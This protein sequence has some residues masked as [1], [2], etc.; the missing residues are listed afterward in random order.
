MDREAEIAWLH[1]ALERQ[2]DKFGCVVADEEGHIDLAASRRIWAVQ[3]TTTKEL[4]DRL[5]ELSAV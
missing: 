2:S 4:A 5:T 1:A 3:E